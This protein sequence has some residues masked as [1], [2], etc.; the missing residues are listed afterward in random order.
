MLLLLLQGTD[1]RLVPIGS[2]QLLPSPRSRAASAQLMRLARSGA[3]PVFGCLD[4][5][6]PFLVPLSR[7][8]ARLNDYDDMIRRHQEEAF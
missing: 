4:D 6:A 8:G 3:A 7:E 2:H 5:S 1:H